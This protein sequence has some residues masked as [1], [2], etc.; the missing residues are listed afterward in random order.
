M[1]LFADTEFVKD[2]ITAISTMNLLNSDNKW[3]DENSIISGGW[4]FITIDKKTR[5]FKSKRYGKSGIE[6]EIC[7]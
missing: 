1:R 5:T 6:R 3:D 2:G 4:D 7:L